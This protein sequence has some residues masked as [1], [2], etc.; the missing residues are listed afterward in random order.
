MDQEGDMKVCTFDRFGLLIQFLLNSYVE[1]G[2]A[3]HEDAFPFS[4]IRSYQRG[5]PE[6]PLT[7]LDI[8]ENK[9]MKKVRVL[10]EHTYGSV[11]KHYKIINI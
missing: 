3:R 8:A 2:A 11:D 4:C 9:I 7:E 5:T 10:I 6:N 1:I